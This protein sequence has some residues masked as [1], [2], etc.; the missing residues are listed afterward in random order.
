MEAAAA[1]AVVA[2]AIVGLA[3]TD[4]FILAAIAVIIFGAAILTEG[5]AGAA[6]FSARGQLGTEAESWT[7]GL[8]SDFLAGVGGIVLGILALLGVASGVLL[9]V[10]ALLFGAAY[11]LSGLGGTQMAWF[12]YAFGG[13]LLV[14]LAAV[15]LGILAV[16]GQDSLTLVLVS[17]LILGAGALFTGAFT[18]MRAASAARE[19]HG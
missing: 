13:Q 8:S 15:V 12:S 11:L 18:S 7:G 16:V 2:L 4:S 3:R 1:L 17:L 19:M 10:A 6:I 5:G 9:S 14:G